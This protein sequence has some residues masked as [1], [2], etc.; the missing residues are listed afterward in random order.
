[1][2]LFLNIL[3]RRFPVTLSEVAP[4]DSNDSNVKRYLWG[5]E[6]EDVMYW[7]PPQANIC[8]DIRCCYFPKVLYVYIFAIIHA[9]ISLTFMV[10]GDYV[11]LG[12]MSDAMLSPHQS[13]ITLTFAQHIR[14]LADAAGVTSFGN[15]SL[16]SDDSDRPETSHSSHNTT[17][18]SSSLDLDFEGRNYSDD[19]NNVNLDE[20]FRKYPSSKNLQFN[21]PFR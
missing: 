1:M 18:S 15:F 10:Y 19:D 21:I 9:G 14:D 16:P 11:R 5:Q 12:V 6:I 20:S 17:T 13:L 7:R 3:S 2:R 4:A 8:K